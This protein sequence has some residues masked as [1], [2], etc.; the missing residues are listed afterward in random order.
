MPS[1]AIVL[2]RKDRDSEKMGKTSYAD[3]DESPNLGMEDEEDTLESCAQELID[4]I[5]SG[6]TEGVVESL[7]DIISKLKQE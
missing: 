4:S 2:G 6:D 5:K 1:L 3:K 7:K